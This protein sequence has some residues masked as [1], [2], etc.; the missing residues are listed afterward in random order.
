M[1]VDDFATDDQ[2]ASKG[3][4]SAPKS[5]ARAKA[6]RQPDTVEEMHSSAHALHKQG[7]KIGSFLEEKP[8]KDGST[9]ASSAK[10]FLIRNITEEEV[11]MIE[12][13]HE[14]EPETRKVA[15]STVL[16]AK[17]K[18]SIYHGR[19]QQVMPD[20]TSIGEHMDFFRDVAYG[21]VHVAQKQMLDKYGDGK[22]DAKL[23]YGPYAA[24]AAK[25]FANGALKLLPVSTDLA[26]D[27]KTQSRIPA[28]SINVEPITT[29]SGGTVSLHNIPFGIEA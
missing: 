4:A 22:D 29:P 20:Y 19:V 24:R 16:G 5:K 26:D 11:E 28:T 17:G 9:D 25:D 14:R 27:S 23:L 13:T 12:C 7:V 6:E 21:A 3:R 15:T 1:W 18:F 8:A 10:I 2:Q